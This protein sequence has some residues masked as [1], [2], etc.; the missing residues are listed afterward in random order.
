MVVEEGEAV[1][2]AN[3]RMM[4][5]MIVVV[6]VVVARLVVVLP[7]FVRH[8]FHVVLVPIQPDVPF[9]LLPD[10]LPSWQRYLF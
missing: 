5:M 9:P 4:T 1:D 3:V 10:Q 7:T 6:F 8:D 2:H